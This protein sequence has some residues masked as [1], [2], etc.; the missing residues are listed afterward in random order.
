[1]PKAPNY[2][3]LKPGAFPNCAPCIQ[4]YAKAKGVPAQFTKLSV[5]FLMCL[6]IMPAV[7]TGADAYSISKYPNYQEND[8]N[9][10]PKSFMNNGQV[11][12]DSHRLRFLAEGRI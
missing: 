8:Q 5:A 11:G 7:G 9:I 12:R 6:L 3:R 2:T 10:Q 4:P 1:M